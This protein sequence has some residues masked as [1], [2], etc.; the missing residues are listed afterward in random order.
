MLSYGVK[1]AQDEERRRSGAT[2]EALHVEAASALAALDALAAGMGAFLA[3]Y[4]PRVLALVL[5]RSI[6]ACC[7]PQVAATASHAW[8]V[9]ASAIPPRLLLPPLFAQLN[10]ALQVRKCFPP[11]CDLTASLCAKLPY[12]PVLCSGR[13]QFKFGNMPIV[14][15]VPIFGVLIIPASFPASQGKVHLATFTTTP[16]LLS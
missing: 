15:C 6:L 2:A 14:A 1:C 8:R 9:L 12:S 7:A 5:Q 16:H 11:H 10:P 13:L 3:P 4:L